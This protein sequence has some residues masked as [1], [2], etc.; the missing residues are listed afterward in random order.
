[1]ASSIRSM[2]ADLALK[3]LSFCQHLV[4]EVKGAD[5]EATVVNTI[6]A[7]QLGAIVST[8]S[9]QLSEAN[10]TLT[11]LQDAEQYLG[12]AVGRVGSETVYFDDDGAERVVTHAARNAKTTANDAIEAVAAISGY[13]PAAGADGAA[14]QSAL[15]H[16]ASLSVKDASTSLD[17]SHLKTSVGNAVDAYEREQQRIR[18][19]QE[20]IARAA[21]LLAAQQEAAREAEREAERLRN[22]QNVTPGFNQQS[23]RDDIDTGSTGIQAS[24]FQQNR[25][26]IGNGN[27]GISNQNDD[28]SNGNTGIKNDDISQ[29]NDGIAP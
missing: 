27:F 19:E 11:R 6:K 25:E 1:M 22:Q 9:T 5:A 3:S 16:S 4:T 13:A 28:I 29:G 24:P 20:R 18:E 7:A 26:D 17:F 21:A 8:V 23:R 15:Q 2:V 12:S 14:I 10:S